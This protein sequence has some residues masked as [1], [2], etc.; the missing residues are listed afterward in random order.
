MKTDHT[1]RS[2]F[3]KLQGITLEVISVAL[4]IGFVAVF[5][6]ALIWASQ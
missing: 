5:L 6:K 4:Y 1:L 3:Q 2:T